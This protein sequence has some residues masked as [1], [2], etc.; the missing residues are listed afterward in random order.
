MIL[1]PRQIN[2]KN[3][4]MDQ[5]L[6]IISRIAL[7][8]CWGAVFL[9]A[10]YFMASG[11]V[12]KTLLFAQFTPIRY[13]LFDISPEKELKRPISLDRSIPLTIFI[14]YL[15][16]TLPVWQGNLMADIQGF[17]IAVFRAN[18]NGY[19]LLWMDTFSFAYKI[20][21]T[22]DGIPLEDDIKMLYEND[23]IERLRKK[24]ENEEDP[25][26]AAEYQKSYEAWKQTQLAT[27]L[28][29]WNFPIR[30][31]VQA[32][33]PFMSLKEIGAQ[34]LDDYYQLDQKAYKE[35]EKMNN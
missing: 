34:P 31:Y 8:F 13:F 28:D 20:R 12:L 3:T 10:L 1:R 32:G 5:E 21:R 16:K 33:D 2:L 17:I 29:K 24:A 23:R 15:G 25:E 7:V 14:R 22:E 30:R 19:A 9:D 35:F 18:I 27:K 26:K 11:N 4:S 6:R